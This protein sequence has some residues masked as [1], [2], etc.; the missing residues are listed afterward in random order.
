MR[1][2]VVTV[3]ECPLLSM[4]L[5]RAFPAAELRNVGVT[6]VDS[7]EEAHGEVDRLI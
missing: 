5:G 3:A 6:R 1:R 2:H 7:D 4:L